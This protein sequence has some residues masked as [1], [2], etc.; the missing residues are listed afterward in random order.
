MA[1]REP[2]AQRRKLDGHPTH[3]KVEV[4]PERLAIDLGL[5][6]GVRRCKD[7]NVSAA[8]ARAAHRAHHLLSSTRSSFACIFALISPDLVEEERAAVGF[9]EQARAVAESA[10]VKA[11]RTCPKSSSSSKF[12]GTDAPNPARKGFAQ[13]ALAS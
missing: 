2:L 13:R 6:A 7:A 4:L 11:P 1:M 8:L 3:P 12:S 5:Q 9:D 10:P